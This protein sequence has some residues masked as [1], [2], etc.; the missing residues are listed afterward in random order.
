MV[1]LCILTFEF[2]CVKGFRLEIFRIKTA[3][4]MADGDSS[5]PNSWIESLRDSSVVKSKTNVEPRNTC[6]YHRDTDAPLNPNEVPADRR[7]GSGMR[8]EAWLCGSIVLS[9]S[10]SPE[11]ELVRTPIMC[12]RDGFDHWLF[13]VLLRGEATVRDGDGSTRMRAGELHLC[14]LAEEQQESWSASEWVSLALPRDA[15][16]ATTAGLERLPRGVLAG[17]CPR[18]LA[19]Y[20]R[21]MARLVPG[22]KAAERA[23]VEQVTRSMIDACVLVHEP[24]PGALRPNKFILQQTLVRRVIDENIGS[25]RLNSQLI[26][27]LTGLSRSTLYRLF[28]GDGGVASFIQ[29]RRLQLVKA[30]LEDNAKLDEPIA[31]IA[32]RWGF[33][34][35]PSFNRSFRRAYG[36]TPRETRAGVAGRMNAPAIPAAP[37]EL[38]PKDSYFAL[39]HQTQRGHA[40]EGESGE[41]GR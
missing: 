36:M 16:P 26:C 22:M 19:D 7:A 5:S 34:C 27:G 6:E 2:P 35:V 11:R 14:S 20:I 23:A 1:L 30:E 33:F 25:A 28:E 37:Q 32:E 10:S 15:F 18:L 17:S 9:R 31:T 21:S 3:V 41:E 38:L 8:H 29:R 12:A 4:T 39:L 40:L 24:G 13:R